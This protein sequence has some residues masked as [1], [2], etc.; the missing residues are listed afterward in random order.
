M[1]KEIGESDALIV[2]G[3]AYQAQTFAFSS[4]FFA[5][6]VGLVIL[7]VFVLGASLSENG[8]PPFTLRLLAFGVT[9]ILADT[10]V[11]CITK[12]ILSSMM[13]RETLT[14]LTI[15]GQKASLIEYLSAM[16]V[17]LRKEFATLQ[18]YKMGNQ[19]ERTT[20]GRLYN[21][22]I[23]GCIVASL[24]IPPV[25]FSFIWWNHGYFVGLLLISQLLYILS[26]WCLFRYIPTM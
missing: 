24:T 23:L 10:A 25:L 7:P 3:Q 9:M 14:R 13:H 11:Y 5:V 18:Q 19:V 16:K 1:S 17:A 12:T 22:Q 26:L 21:S 4:I 20:L 2:L 6:S 15:E 8:A